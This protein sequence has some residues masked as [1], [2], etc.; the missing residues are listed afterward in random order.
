MAPTWPRSPRPTVANLPVHLDRVQVLRGWRRP[1]RRGWPGPAVVHRGHAE[2]AV[3]RPPPSGRGPPRRLPAAAP[4]ARPPVRRVQALRRARRQP[5]GRH[6]LVLRLLQRLPPAP[7]VRHDPRHRARRTTRS[8]G[9]PRRRRAR[10]DPG[11][12]GRSWRADPL[13]GSGRVLVLGIATALWAGIGA[14]GALQH[15]LDDVAD[16]PMH[17]RGN[18]LVRKGKAITFL[19]LLA[20]GIAASTSC[21]TWRRCSTRGVV[22]GALGLLATFVVNVLLLIALFTVLPA[23]RQPL[24]RP[25]AGRRRRRRRA[26]RSCSSSAASSCAASSPAPATPTARSP[27]VI[28]LLSW[29]FLVSR[30]LLLAAE[31][32]Y[33]LA[34]Q[35]WPRRLV[36]ADDADRRRPPGDAAR[37][38]AASS[39]T[40]GSATPSVDGAGRDRRRAARR[41]RRSAGDVEVTGQAAD[42]EQPLDRRAGRPQHEARPGSRARLW[43]ASTMTRSPEES[44]NVTPA[45]SRTSTGGSA[46][47]RSASSG[48]V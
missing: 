47:R 20:V 29:F 41:G 17:D 33:V 7:G 9:R 25:A 8:C 2:P 12:R 23:Q 34:D 3:K 40:P 10:A 30:V 45:R 18:A 35:L 6:R 28:A 48:A 37:R 38:A 24:R 22:T 32:N 43:W 46:A 5:S 31:L 19:A 39:A 16:V 42:L 26:A 36:A 1:R 27:I 11:D 21:P 15:G 14:V 4:A 13:P 44:M